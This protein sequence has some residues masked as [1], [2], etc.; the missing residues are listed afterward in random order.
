MEVEIIESRNTGMKDMENNIVENNVTDTETK[1]SDLGL[2][3]II[4]KSV[5]LAGY[6]HPTPIQ[7]LAIPVALK[8]GDIL[9]TAQTGTGKTAAFA[10]PILHKLSTDDRWSKSK[11]P[12]ALILSPTRELAVQI[13]ENIKAY[14]AGLNLKSLIV[15]GGVSEQSQIQALKNGVDILIATPGRLLDLLERRF[16][17]LKEIQ[18]FVLDEADRMLDMGFFP[19]IKRIEKQIPKSRQNMFFSATMPKEIKALAD[20]FLQNP[21][22]I[23]VDPVSSAPKK[24]EQR[25]LFVETANKR[26]LLLH[27]LKDKAL[28]KI[29]V[30]TRTKHAANR[31]AEFLQKN[32]IDAKPIHGNKSQNARQSALK[33]LTSGQLRVLVATD[34]VARGID[35]DD[36]SHVINYDIPNQAESYVHRIGR[37]GRAGAV[38]TAIAFCDMEEKS[39]LRDIEK[40]VDQTLEIDRNHP[41]HSDKIET[42]GVTSSGVAKSRI[43]SRGGGGRGRQG[44]GRS[45]NQFGKPASKRADNPFNPKPNR[46]SRFGKAQPKTGLNTAR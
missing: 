34:I 3:P 29:I 14:S 27:L 15:F 25:I 44:G 38:G 11:N 18:V 19:D 35:I 28:A 9:G 6:T 21:V 4:L 46:S 37:S 23:Q 33:E 45:N 5:E 16:M 24:I 36:I 39:F 43:E 31:V 17:N 8:N 26:P 12:R 20:S 7:R 42:A 32:K 1:F 22:R 2:N 40:I 30:F 13:G 10:L 41:F